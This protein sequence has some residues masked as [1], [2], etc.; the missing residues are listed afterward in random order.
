L[1]YLGFPVPNAI[2]S[3]VGRDKKSR[4]KNNIIG[5]RNNKLINTIPLYFEVV[6]LIDRSYKEFSRGRL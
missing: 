1:K 4:W 6:S 3:R 5:L 2:D